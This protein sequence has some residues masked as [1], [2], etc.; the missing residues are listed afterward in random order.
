MSQLTK[1]QVQK[2]AKLSRLELTDEELKKY[3]EQLSQILNYV[4]QLNEV[5]TEGKAVTAQ[6]T[7]I[8]NVW[9][10][11]EIKESKIKKELLEQAPRVNQD[12]GIIV[13]RV[14]ES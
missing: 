7:G 5:K 8:T 1:E 12:G 11:D 14:F 2:I 6:V 10:D 9:R 3:A 4:N 13:K